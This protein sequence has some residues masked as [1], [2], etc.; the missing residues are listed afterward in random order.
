MNKKIKIILLVIILC[1]FTGV[2]YNNIVRDKALFVTVFADNDKLDISAQ[3]H[4]S[5]AGQIINAYYDDANSYYLFVPFYAKDK[6]VMFETSKG[7]KITQVEEDEYSIN[8]EGQLYVLY[9]SSIPFIDVSLENGMEYLT[10]DKS[11]IDNGQI[12]IYSSEGDILYT[13]E[14]DEMKGRGNSSWEMDK[15]PLQFK[16]P[17]PMEIGDIPST[18]KFSLVSARDYTFLRNYISNEMSDCMGEAPLSCMHVDLYI[19]HEYQ[20]MYELWNK[21]EPETLGIYDLEEENKTTTDMLEPW[22]QMTTNTYFEDW[23]NTVTGK[24][25]D[26]VDQTDEITGGYILEC[27]YA[28]RYDEEA[29]GFILDS[30]AYIVSKS[31]KYLSEEQYNYIS[32]YMKTCEFVLGESLRLG[33]PEL[34]YDYIDVE[35]FIVKYLVEE[36]SKNYECS[37]TSLYLY[38]DIEDTLHAGPAWDYDSAYGAVDDDSELD[39][40]SPEGF[41]AREIPGSFTW[42]QLLYY[43]PRFYEEMVQVYNQTLYP[44]LNDLTEELI[45]QWEAKLSNSAVMDSIKWKRATSPEAALEDYKYKVS[46]VSDFISVRKEFLYNEWK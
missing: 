34:I 29:S 4:T 41:A 36:V 19:D 1:V 18:N 40:A 11:N 23:N 15:K 43:N 21:V 42:W 45:P 10:E 8:G 14:L 16:L 2:S 44:Y 17:V 46:K 30:G 39:F 7:I 32:D 35:S 26:Y 20:G 25:W 38:K 5:D 27:D 37:S 6:K 12:T 28:L 22:Q 3:I 31:P 33:T 9:G 13:G 24:W